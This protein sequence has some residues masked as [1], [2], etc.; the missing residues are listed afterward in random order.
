MTLTDDRPTVSHPPA[1]SG[2]AG[3]RGSW[4]VS[5]RMAR[6]DVRRHKGRSAI[7]A[8]MAGLPIALLCFAFTLFATTQITGAERIPG[9]IGTAVAS[10]NPPEPSRVIQN[11]DLS[12]LGSA[13]DASGDVTPALPIP[14]YEAGSSLAAQGRALDRFLHGTAIATVLYN[15]KAALTGRYPDVNIAQLDPRARRTP[16]AQLV[17]G[18]WPRNASEAV[19]SQDSTVSGLPGSGRLT[20]L[21]G[22]SRHTVTVVGTVSTKDGTDVFTML[23]PSEPGSV[24]WLLERSSPMS[25]PEV[26]RLNTYGLTVLSADVLR[27][28]PP[29]DQID[30]QVGESGQTNDA[31][32]Y[33]LGAVFLALVVVLLTAPAFAVSASR[34]RRT[35][36]LAAAN[37]ADQR[38]LRRGVLAQGVVLGGLSVVVAVV[39][40]VTAAY[41]LTQVRPPTRDW[42]GPWDIPWLAILGVGLLGIAACVAAAMLPAMRLGRLDVVAVMKG[43]SVSP[44][45]RRWLA[46]AGLLLT[47]MSTAFLLLA[48]MSSSS[49]VTHSPG[50]EACSAAVVGLCL[51]ALMIV[52]WLLVT[53]GQRCARLPI[54]L[55]LAARDTARHRTRSIPTVAATLAAT[56]AVVAM[57]ISFASSDAY[58]ARDYVPPTIAGESLV[59]TYGNPSNAVT[60]ELTSTVRRLYPSYVV[61]SLAVVSDP[62]ARAMTTWAP[63]E[64]DPTNG[65]FTALLLPG[66]RLSEAL[67]PPSGGYSS[68]LPLPAAQRCNRYNTAQYGS[69]SGLGILP[70]AE[71]ARRLKLSPTQREAVT[72]GALV[73]LGD[74]LPA[75]VSVATAAY[76]VDD[77]GQAPGE[78]SL[79]SDLPV[80]A[81]PT[82]DEARAA[83]TRYAGVLVTPETAARLGWTPLA[84]SAALIVRDP[85]GPI[86]TAA[87]RAIN[88][89]LTLTGFHVERGFQGRYAVV[90]P[91]LLA[92]LLA[93]LLVTTLTSTALAMAEQRSDDATMAAVGATRGTRR[94]M[95][96]GHAYW[97]GIIATVFGS[98]AG[99]VIGQGLARLAVGGQ[100][101]TDDGTPADASPFLTVPWLPIAAIVVVAPVIAAL[102]AG[103]AIR[104][105][106]QVTRRTT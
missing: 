55:R 64:K 7:V 13:G 42:S 106:P 71:I 74:D 93:L 57:L 105:A 28:P 84:T 81:I 29:A 18:R 100:M 83:F 66:C 69:N 70:I 80:I 43:Q 76:H 85:S 46:V 61:Q 48:P 5:L 14:G 98:L 10:F 16:L 22:G 95:A 54:A 30:P 49:F 27:N 99:L 21:A 68:D 17:S 2:A 12:M 34:Q 90:F 94:L 19:V 72:G 1:A 86:S 92:C 4:R 96:A 102:L 50:R 15:G 26:R 6:R 60:T 62:Y 104:R 33:V 78:E 9:E 44:P 23:A 101:P 25:W 56:A 35:L 45:L 97:L 65:R 41:V 53:L 51:G 40:G 32:A 39:V 47:G 87:E 77:Q 79:T 20:L 75:R 31:G 52:P 63:G 24:T 38:Q 58:Q 91:I 3:W 37:G 36:A 88:D 89:Q 59:D 103:A 11:G 82:S 8:L 73:V 67:E